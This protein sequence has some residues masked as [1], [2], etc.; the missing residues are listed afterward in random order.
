LIEANKIGKFFVPNE[1]HKCAL[2]D[3]M[4]KARRKEENK[5]VGERHHGNMN[6]NLIKLP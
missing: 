3:M 1:I 6:I 2:H 5:C 4:P